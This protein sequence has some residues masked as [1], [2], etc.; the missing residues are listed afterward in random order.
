MHKIYPE[1]QVCPKIRL[2]PEI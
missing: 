2:C 1:K